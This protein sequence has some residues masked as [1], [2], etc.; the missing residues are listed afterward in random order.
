MALRTALNRCAI[1]IHTK[2]SSEGISVSVSTIERVIAKF[3]TLKTK[4]RH[5]RWTL[6][7]PDVTAPG[8]GY[9]SLRQ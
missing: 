7:R 9:H 3:C 2:L 4:R 1:I 5:V 6:P 8:D